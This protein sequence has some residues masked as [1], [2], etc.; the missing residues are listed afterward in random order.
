M[1]PMAPSNTLKP[2]RIEE[3]IDRHIPALRNLA[4]ID[5]QIP[6]NLDSSNIGPD[7]WI[8][9]H[10]LIVKNYDT[11]D[12]FIIIHGTDTLVY[13]A[14]AISYL[15]TAFSKP[16]IFTGSQRPLSAIRSDAR[17]NL[18]NAVE[19][20]TMDIPEVTICFD[21]KLYRANRT[22][23]QSIE[24]YHGFDSPNYPPLARIGLS[25]KLFPNLFWIKKTNYR[26]EPVL[27][28]NILIITLFPGSNFQQYLH[29]LEE[30]IAG[31]ILQGF[32]SGNLP[33]ISPNWI[34]FVKK[35]VD[36]GK[37]VFIGSQSQHGTVDLNLYEC[38]EKALDAGAVSLKDMTIEAALVKLMIVTGN[39]DDKDKIQ[40]VMV[41]PLAGELTE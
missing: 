9:L 18:I 37:S 16:I 28:K 15:T 21:N 24:S 10:A 1:T 12:G 36:N 2:G 11:Y 14:A 40:H 20:A 31:I 33:E 32:G 25:M 7:E 13:T 27:N 19:L 29:F 4:E 22:I 8:A 6:F 30:D 34:S 41:D 5:I 17:M 35:A 23:K 3:D 38:G 26:F 39:F